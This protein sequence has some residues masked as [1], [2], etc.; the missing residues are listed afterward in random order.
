M[1]LI[2][3]P[4]GSGKS[5]SCLIQLKAALG[6]KLDTCRLIVPTATMAEHLRNEL[7]REGFVFKPALVSTFT[8]F[9]EPYY[10]ATQGVSSGAIE[11]VA[12]EVLART[13]L[14]TYSAVRNFAGFRASIVRSI[15]EVSSAGATP[16]DLTSAG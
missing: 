16:A 12:K 3:G 7:A 6:D 1:N 15:E 5:V 4:P 2:L 8:K 14:K 9:V 10:L 13:P 11:I